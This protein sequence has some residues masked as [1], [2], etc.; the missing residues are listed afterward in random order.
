MSV[1]HGSVEMQGSWRPQR[2]T[3]FSFLSFHQN[4]PRPRW[5]LAP[6]LWTRSSP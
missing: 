2:S 6:Q 1:L 4:V 3:G 5:E